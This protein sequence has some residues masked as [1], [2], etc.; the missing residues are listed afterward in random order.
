MRYG[1]SAT[2]V[3]LEPDRLGRGAEWAVVRETLVNGA[4]RGRGLWLCGE[5]GV[6]KSVLLEQTGRYAAAQGMRVL[7]VS[8]AEAE[9]DLP[10]AALH[11]L[12]WPLREYVDEISGP[13]RAVLYWALAMGHAEPVPS[14][15][16]SAATLE[17]LVA[18]ARRQPLLIAIDDMH[19]L[20]ASSAEV[21]HF[22]EL[23]L[24]AVPI[25]MVATLREEALSGRDTS[26][27]RVL[28]VRPLRDEGVRTLL[29]ERHPGLSA[30]A[31]TRILREAAGNPLALVEMPSQ[32]GAPERYGQLPLPDHLPLGERL[33]RVFA[34]RVEALG[35]A[36]RFTLLLCAVAGGDEPVHRIAAAAR[37]ADIGD[38]D[39][40]LAT[41]Q[42]R[43][44]IQIDDHRRVRLRHPLV[45]SSLVHGARVTDR[46]RAHAAWAE[47]LAEG[48][49][50]QVIH[51]AEATTQP[52]ETVAGALV[53]VAGQTESRGCDVE[54]AHL[55]AR[56]AA[57]SGDTDGRGS[58]LV[59]AACAAARGNHIGLAARLLDQAIAHGVPA[60]GRNAL[61]FTRA[62]VRLHADGDPG[63][64][65]ELLP[66]LLDRL[67]AEESELRLPVLFLLMLA[68]G[69]TADRQAWEAV[70]TRLDGTP[71]IVRLGCDIWSDP[72]R[73]LQGGH[74]RLEAVINS[75]TGAGD[76]GAGDV[77]T[78]E[79]WLLLW[80]AAGLDAVG[81]H[82]PL[83]E[84]MVDRYPYA[85]RSLFEA[86]SAYDDYLR[87]DWDRCVERGRAAAIVARARGSAFNAAVHAYKAAYVT[88]ARGD[89][90]AVDDLVAELR[91]WA[92]A[93]GL[94]FIVHRLRAM[95]SV[96]AL[97]LGDYETAY[98]HA[99]LLTPPGTLP[100]G[101][102]QF[103]LI[104]LDLVESAQHTGRAA[105][106]RRHVAAGRAVHMER[107]SP[108]HACVLLAAEAMASDDV[109]E[110]CASVYASP[111]AAVWP[112]ELARVRL[113]HGAWLRRQGR[114]ADARHQL[115]AAEG[116][117]AALKADPWRERTL[118]ELRVCHEPKAVAAPPGLMASLTPQE[119]RIAELVA[120]GFSNRDV[121]ARLCLSRRTVASHLYK[122][123]PK[124][125][126]TTRAG[127]ARAL[128]QW[129]ETG[130]E[131]RAG[132]LAGSGSGGGSGSGSKT[133]GSA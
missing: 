48:E 56:A 91:P 132:T 98:G 73:R 108:H 10:F 113:F 94:T 68:A 55:Y 69:Y 118:E 18:V 59:A 29:T 37:R 84:G 89:R 122:I 41:A 4:E 117:F 78:A 30:M 120:A 35:P 61:D 6:G 14:Y 128:E 130:T 95:Q 107:M 8:G 38:V 77:R 53:A 99:A 93:R 119:L 50:R 32:L 72:A 39:T 88:A 52:D 21:L 9:R 79:T 65:V 40:F 31:R 82:V 106:A 22:L 25:V 33:E 45:R 16:V 5:P 125:D 101:V 96:C 12:L 43:G 24:A 114:R 116:A 121:G 112:F 20:D 19:W 110:A 62:L 27:V 34:H 90:R 109:D 63:P 2:Y 15:T 71:E 49:I 57:L 75:L 67:T 131:T 36:V 103:H 3:L 66:G 111:D 81:D 51:R 44:L 100:A 124:L 80:A 64:A 129:T 104:F 7:N 76:P 115:A 102:S 85:T 127:V 1:T 60:G 92:V 42:E 17:L 123:Y 133:G 105:E 126:V 83:W 13:G 47:V 87:G 23:R 54:A 26:G 86:V 46:R 28:D 58:R 70:E 97:A 74:A 11:Q